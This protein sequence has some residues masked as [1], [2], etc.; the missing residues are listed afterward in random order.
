M[1]E[2][3]YVEFL[4]INKLIYKII[5]LEIDENEINTEISRF[6]TINKFKFD[7]YIEKQ[8]KKDLKSYPKIFLKL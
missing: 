8:F 5:Y 1:V 3:Y 2:L 7:N 6:K 4:Y